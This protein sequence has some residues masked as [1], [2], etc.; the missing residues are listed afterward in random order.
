MYTGS[1]PA[2]AQLSCVILRLLLPTAHSLTSPLG[3]ESQMAASPRFS[4]NTIDSHKPM[5][6]PTCTPKLA[7]HRVILSEVFWQRAMVA[8][9][10]DASKLI[11][12]SVQ[13]SIVLPWTLMWAKSE[14]YKFS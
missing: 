3:I 2:G 5:C 9:P 12:E 7:Q 6:V 11:P 4:F 10:L 14:A 8:V 1:R 13:L